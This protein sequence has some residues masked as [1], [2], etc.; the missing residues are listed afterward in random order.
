MILVDTIRY[1]AMPQRASPQLGRCHCLPQRMSPVPVVARNF[2]GYVHVLDFLEVQF[3]AVARWRRE[4]T[5]GDAGQGGWPGTSGCCRT[6][7]PRCPVCNRILAIADVDGDASQL[8][9]QNLTT[10]PNPSTTSRR[11]WAAR[12]CSR[13][14]SD[15]Q[16]S[17]LRCC[18]R[19]GRSCPPSSPRTSA[20][21]PRRTRSCV[22]MFRYGRVWGFRGDFGQ[23]I[24]L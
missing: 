17:G 1:L 16:G 18:V 14:G 4:G 23:T 12:F 2:V 15:W 22:E 9:E 7:P 20:P 19:S 21:L 3:A 8:I 24:A 11:L 5:G 6:R 13:A 10:V